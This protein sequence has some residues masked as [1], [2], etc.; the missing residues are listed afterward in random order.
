MAPSAKAELLA[1]EGLGLRSALRLRAHWATWADAFNMVRARHPEIAEVI[2][3]AVGA[4]DEV[5]SVQAV[6]RSVDSFGRRWI[7]PAHLEELAREAVHPPTAEDG[8]PN[9]L[10]VGWQAAAGRAVE[11]SSLRPT[12]SNAEGA[13]HRSQG[14]PLAPSPFVS[15]PTNRVSRLE[16]QTV[17][18]LF[19][20]R[21]RLPLLPHSSAFAVAVLS[22]SLAITGRVLSWGRRGFPLKNAAARICRE[23]GGRVRTIMSLSWTSSTHEGSR[24]W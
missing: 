12:L 19:L 23:V 10:R 13:L 17:R 24:L 4:R 2:Q 16:P 15:F 1:A 9:Q 14:G 21:L 3:R 11:S 6:N 20:R 22:T 5:P 18:V 8:E 7:C